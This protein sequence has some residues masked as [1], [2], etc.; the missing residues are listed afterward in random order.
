[1]GDA[2]KKLI[3]EMIYKRVS[4]EMQN[5]QHIDDMAEIDL[6]TRNVSNEAVGHFKIL[7]DSIQANPKLVNYEEIVKRII[8]DRI[9]VE[10][11]FD[12]SQE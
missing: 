7:Y 6:K 3:N 8:A 5:E 11:V 10:K 4:R 1:M 9:A 2:N 12:F